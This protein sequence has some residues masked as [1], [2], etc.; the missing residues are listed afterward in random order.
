MRSGDDIYRAPDELAASLQR[1]GHSKLAAR[2][3][4]RQRQVAW[5]TRPELFEE[6]EIVLARALK[7]DGA[8]LSG[9]L[10]ERILSAIPDNS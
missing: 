6:L 8:E 2:I 1:S 10:G 3:Q 4:D 7:S 9:T 5:T